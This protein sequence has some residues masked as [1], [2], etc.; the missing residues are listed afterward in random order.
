[1]TLHMLVTCVFTIVEKMHIASIIVSLGFNPVSFGPLLGQRASQTCSSS[2]HISPFGAEL[3]IEPLYQNIPLL[4][5]IITNFL[6]QYLP[7]LSLDLINLNNSLL[8]FFLTLVHI[9]SSNSHL[10]MYINWNNI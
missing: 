9:P 5:L 10:I 1:M 2:L 6:C 8:S 7:L 3:T 4:S